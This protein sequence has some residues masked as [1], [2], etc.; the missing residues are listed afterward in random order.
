MAISGIVLGSV[1]IIFSMVIG[2]FGG[3]F[4]MDWIKGGGDHMIQ[5]PRNF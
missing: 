1:A 5:R 3:M 4:F 2:M